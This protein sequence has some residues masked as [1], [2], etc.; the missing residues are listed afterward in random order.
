MVV[1]G[2]LHV[3]GWRCVWMVVDGALCGKR[4]CK[5]LVVKRVLCVAAAVWALK[6]P[7]GR[8]RKWYCC[9][10]KRSGGLGRCI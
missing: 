6:C 4:E 3:E 2:A 10:R 8:T 7:W 1:V 5:R 9:D